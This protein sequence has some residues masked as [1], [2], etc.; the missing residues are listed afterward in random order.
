MFLRVLSFNPCM[1]IS[2]VIAC[3]YFDH[4]SGVYDTCNAAKW[5]HAAFHSTCAIVGAG[6]LGL[7]Y[8]FSYLGWAAGL[9]TLIT[10]TAISFYTSWLLAQLHE[11]NGARFDT[12]REIGESVWGKILL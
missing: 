9:V 2:P 5:W 12:Y 4:N 10:L 8:A 1:K 11:Y 7:P 3:S 6:V